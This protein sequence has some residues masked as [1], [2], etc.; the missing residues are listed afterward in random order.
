MISYHYSDFQISGT[1]VRSTSVYFGNVPLVWSS[2]LQLSYTASILFPEQGLFI[3][4]QL[5]HPICV[6]R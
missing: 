3:V 6:W 5:S 1:L 2:V 4:P